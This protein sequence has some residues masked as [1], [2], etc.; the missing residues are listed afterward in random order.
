MYIVVYFS[1]SG[2]PKSGL[3]P[4]IIIRQI[5]TGE[6]IINGGECV[7]I[8]N[9]FYRYDFVE[10]DYTKNYAI[11]CDGG[12][13]LNDYE[14]YVVLGNDSIVDDMNYALENNLT[15]QKVLGLLH[16]N[17]SIDNT[18]YDQFGNLT[19]ARV[20]LYDDKGNVG[21]DSGIIGEYQMICVAPSAGKFT[22]W[23]QISSD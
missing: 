8:G 9:G 5:S 6:M 3:L 17:M 16:H 1:E 14:R 21:T 15:L 4:T 12:I 23:K 10:Y 22:L 18:T 13:V 19:N 11:L 2:V 20:R 7:E